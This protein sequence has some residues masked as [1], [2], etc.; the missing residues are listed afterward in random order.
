MLLPSLIIKKIKKN[1]KNLIAWMY[2]KLLL[3]CCIWLENWKVSAVNG[4]RQSCVKKMFVKFMPEVSSND[5]FFS[6]LISTHEIFIISESTI[7]K[8][9]Y[10]TTTDSFVLTTTTLFH[11]YRWSGCNDYAHNVDIKLTLILI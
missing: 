10:S 7:L 1:N 3:L 6:L 2:G 9:N 5:S 8:F 11:K 4:L